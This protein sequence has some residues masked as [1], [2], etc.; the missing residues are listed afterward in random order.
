MSQASRE[1][2]RARPWSL[3]IQAGPSVVGGMNLRANV[4]SQAHVEVFNAT[5]C[6]LC[7]AFAFTG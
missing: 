7:F 6:F 4:S 5:Q 3:K 2:F 1:V